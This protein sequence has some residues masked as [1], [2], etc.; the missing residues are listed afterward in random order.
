MA[1]NVGLDESVEA[2]EETFAVI[3]LNFVAVGVPTVTKFGK[4]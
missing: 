3:H 2:R 4:C 1:K